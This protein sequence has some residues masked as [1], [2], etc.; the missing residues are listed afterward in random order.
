VGG[1]KTFTGARM[2]SRLELAT[3]ALL[4]GVLVSL[5]AL[6]MNSEN[7]DPDGQHD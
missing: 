1:V 3:F 6:P 7:V 5:K 4:H 2:L